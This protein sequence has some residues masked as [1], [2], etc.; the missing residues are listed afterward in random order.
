MRNCLFSS[1]FTGKGYVQTPTG[2]QY[3]GVQ[4]EQY[5]DGLSAAQ[6]TER[7]KLL[8]SLYTD[9]SYVYCAHCGQTDQLGNMAVCHTCGDAWCPTCSARH[10]VF[11]TQSYGKGMVCP[12]CRQAGRFGIAA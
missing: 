12:S 1:F 2:L 7:F 6:R 9:P 5:D 4:V 3:N 8:L 11:C 10:P